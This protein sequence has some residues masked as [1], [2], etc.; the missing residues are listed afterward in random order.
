MEADLTSIQPSKQEIEIERSAHISFTLLL[1]WF[2][3]SLSLSNAYS[4]QLDSVGSAGAFGSSMSDCTTYV[5]T[6]L[7]STEHPTPEEVKQSVDVCYTLLNRESQISEFNVRAQAYEQQYSSTSVLLWMVVAITVSGV[8]LA[9]LQLLAS[10]RLAVA[11]GN[12]LDQTNE[13]TL[14]RNQIV[15]KSSVTGLS[16]MLLSFAFFLVFVRYVYK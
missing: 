2:L 9:G 5:L 15:L 4:A 3:F 8:V 11:T 6:L 14:A 13:L 10:Y 12:N 16:I 7:K 1:L